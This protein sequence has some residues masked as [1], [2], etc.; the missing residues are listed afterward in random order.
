MNKG[1]VRLGKIDNDS[2]FLNLEERFEDWVFR[3]A[4][5]LLPFFIILGLILFVMLCYA[6]IGVSAT[7]SGL[8]YNQ[9]KNII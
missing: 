1:P 7:D 9:M 3:Y 2:P 5:I 4:H 6:I 8:E